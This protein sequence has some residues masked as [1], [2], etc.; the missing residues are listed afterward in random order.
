[1]NTINKELINI[2]G[3][4]KSVNLKVIDG[5]NIYITG[6]L[7]KIARIKDEQCD[8]GVRDP[9]IIISELKK[10]KLADIFTFD[11]KPPNTYRRFNYYFE[12]DN[13]AVLEIKS[14]E[15]WFKNQIRNDVR[16]MIRK[17]EKNNLVVKVVPF[18]DELVSGIKK[19]YDETPLRQGIP[20]W[21]YNKD[22]E[23]IKND[24]SSFLDRSDFICV[25]YKN[26]LIG[27]ERII[28]TGK[29]ADPI[30]LIS[31]LKHRNKAPTNALIAKTIQIC[32]NKGIT[33]LTYGKYFYG[34]K[35]G[36]SLNDFK[37]RNGFV[38]YTF[39]RYYIPLTLKGNIA[40]K[41]KLYKKPIEIF[42]SFAITILSKLR[43]KLYLLK[44]SI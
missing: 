11:E 33:H 17:A 3:K 43:T 26:E 44:Y 31:T 24:N 23:T 39:P 34:K 9:E 2:K 6:K 40:L 5:K 14:Y 25:Y 18:T 35:R 19:I 32:A 16:R 29:R 7:I 15:Y 36:D 30:Q 21:H 8:N 12:W 13:L 28:Y 10:Y 38:E 1:M 37:K 4:K 41:L 42:P 20:S 22:L 27:F